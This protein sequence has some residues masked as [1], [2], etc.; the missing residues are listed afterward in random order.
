MAN[1][2]SQFLLGIALCGDMLVDKLQ[3]EVQHLVYLGINRIEVASPFVHTGDTGD[4]KYR[5]GV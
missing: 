4:H 2:L 3:T 1:L 5:K